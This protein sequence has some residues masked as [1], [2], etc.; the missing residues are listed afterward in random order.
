MKGRVFFFQKMRGK[1][2]FSFCGSSLNDISLYLKQ[3][4][5]LDSPQEG[6]WFL[7]LSFVHSPLYNRLKLKCIR[8]R[9]L[10]LFVNQGFLKIPGGFFEEAPSP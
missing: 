2:N 1:D 7:M 9:K 10:I 3:K 5:S 6:A 4:K 8:E